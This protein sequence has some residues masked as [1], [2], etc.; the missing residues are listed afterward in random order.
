MIPITFKIIKTD[1]LNIIKGHR[2]KSNWKLLT[3]VWIFLSF[4]KW[5]LVMDIEYMNPY[6]F[7]PRSNIIVIITI[8]FL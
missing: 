6:K 7:I 2:F 1:M 5:Y 8:S 4:K 3:L